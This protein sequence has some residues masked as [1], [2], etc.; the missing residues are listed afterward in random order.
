M[1]Y[2]NCNHFSNKFCKIITGNEI[3]SHINRCAKI[4]HWFTR[5]ASNIVSNVTEFVENLDIP[6]PQLVDESKKGE[7]RNDTKSKETE[8]S[9]PSE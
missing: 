9:K 5:T 8:N 1:S 6:L 7:K 4:A 3:P 2:S